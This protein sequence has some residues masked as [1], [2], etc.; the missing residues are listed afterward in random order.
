MSTMRRRIE[1]LPWQVA[2]RITERQTSG[3]DVV[4]TTGWVFNNETGHELTLAEFV[5]SGDTEVDSYLNLFGVDPERSHH[6]TL[7]EI[8]CGIGRMTCAFSRRFRSVVACDLDAGFLERCR[9]TVAQL[10]RPDRLRTL[11]VAD[12]RTLELPSDRA[13]YSFSFITLQ[14]CDRDDA[15][16]LTSEAVRVAKPGGRVMLNYRAHGAIDALILPLGAI[17]RGTSRIPG[18][19]SWLSRR[20]TLTRLAWQANRFAP[21]QVVDSVAGRISDVEVWHN[22]KRALVANGATDRTFEGINPN[23]WWLVATVV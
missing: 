5:K 6:E 18:V 2:G 16:A 3:D 12:G 11:E 23:H 22:P 8:G 17:A 14:H 10:G 7:V 4:R 20:R 19:G 9:E 1:F 21:D 15:L 13:D